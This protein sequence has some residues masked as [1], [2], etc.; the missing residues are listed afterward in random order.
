M[1]TYIKSVLPLT[2]M[3]VKYN[4]RKKEKHTWPFPALYIVFLYYFTFT[5]ETNVDVIAPFKTDRESIHSGCL[6][7]IQRRSRGK[8]PRNTAIMLVV[9]QGQIFKRFLWFW[10]GCLPFFLGRLS[11]WVKIMLH[12]ENQL[13]TMS[14]SYLKICVGEWWCWKWI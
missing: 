10:K 11:S 4:I 6:L 2:N 3:M 1:K 9:V 14:G 8:S 7:S 13:C 12:T 5:F